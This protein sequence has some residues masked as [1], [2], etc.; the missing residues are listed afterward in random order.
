MRKLDLSWFF[1]GLL[2]LLSVVL[3]SNEAAAKDVYVR[4]YTR[5]D[6]TYVRP[7]YRSAPDGTTTN[8][9]STKGNINPYTGKPGTKDPY[10]G[11]ANHKVSSEVPPSITS[12][13]QEGA[14]VEKASQGD[15]NQESKDYFRRAY[16]D[17]SFMRGSNGEAYCIKRR[18]EDIKEI[19]E[20]RKDSNFKAAYIDCKFMRGSNGEA[21][22]IRRRIQDI[23]EIEEL[24]TSA[25]FSKA[26]KDCDFM[27]GSNGEASCISRRIGEIKEIESL[28]AG[29][30]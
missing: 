28:A 27:R 30:K 13:G 6:G 19:E 8:N 7:H 5:K 18:I 4:G 25:Y 2:I 23:L 24:R 20:L 1:L 22:C 21:S 15:Q 12:S 3:V 29:S 11:T 14:M 17:C 16:S 10:D 9:F 26:Y